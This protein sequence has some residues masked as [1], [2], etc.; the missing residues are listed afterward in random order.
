MTHVR[1]PR[2]HTHVVQSAR[3]APGMQPMGGAAAARSGQLAAL[4]R[5]LLSNSSSFVACLCAQ[6]PWMRRQDCS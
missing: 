5:D 3:L 2:F 1:S 4:A 6:W